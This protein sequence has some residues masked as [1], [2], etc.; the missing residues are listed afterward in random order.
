MCSKK[1]A[2]MLASE[3][4]RII[5]TTA[6]YEPEV[7]ARTKRALETSSPKRVKE[8]SSTGK[9]LSFKL[10]HKPFGKKVKNHHPRLS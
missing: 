6:L 1:V 2:S 8:R 4:T 9:R 3:S 5:F 10:G 7:N